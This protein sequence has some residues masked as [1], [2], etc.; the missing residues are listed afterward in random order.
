[1][2]FRGYGQLQNDTSSADANT[3]FEIRGAR[4]FIRERGELV[5]VIERFATGG[6]K[7]LAKEPHPFFG[8]MTVA[9][10]EA[11]MWKHLDH[12]VRQFGG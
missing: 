5:R 9:E 1:M 8:V 7:G 4:D 10:R 11:L 2:H 12:H 6:P 3:L